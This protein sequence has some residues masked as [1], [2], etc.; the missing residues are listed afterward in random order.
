MIIW[1]VETR[2]GGEVIDGNLFLGSSLELCEKFIRNNLDLITTDKTHWAVYAMCLDYDVY[3][4]AVCP[5]DYLILQN[6]NNDL[7]YYDAKGNKKE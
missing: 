7:F 1:T 2:E 5:P 6:N 4:D 3:N